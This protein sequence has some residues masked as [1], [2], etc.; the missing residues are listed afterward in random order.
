MSRKHGYSE[1]R[2]PMTRAKATGDHEQHPD[3]IRV[4]SSKTTR[5]ARNVCRVP[6][7][8]GFEMAEAANGLQ[9]IE[10]ALERLPHI[11]VMDLS[12]PQMD[13]WETARRLR[14]DTRTAGIPI[15]ALTGHVLADFSK[16][17]RESGFDGFLT[18]PCPP[19]DLVAEIHESSTPDAD[20][21][22][23]ILEAVPPSK[24]MP[25]KIDGIEQDGSRL[26]RH[27]A[28]QLKRQHARSR[29]TAG[30]QMAKEKAR[31][32]QGTRRSAPKDHGNS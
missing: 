23:Q 16:R 20:T 14:E 10:R 12:L 1:P 4:L 29:D 13:G 3:K 31:R 6:H 17:A 15:L 25:R 22:K 2:Q 19:E 24:H 11:V 28:G 32:P 26:A 8:C 5:C 18:K 21:R 7:T 27:T 9:A 30:E